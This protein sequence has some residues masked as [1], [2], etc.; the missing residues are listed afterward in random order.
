M[1]LLSESEFVSERFAPFLLV[2][3]VDVELFCSPDKVILGKNSLL[4]IFLLCLADSK[5]CLSA[6]NL[7]YSLE[8]FQYKILDC[9]ARED[10][11]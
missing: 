11:Y 10:L 3:L 9:L 6:F 1:V 2:R 5:L 4:D 8:L 7:N